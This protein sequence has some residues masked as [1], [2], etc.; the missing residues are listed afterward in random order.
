[1]RGVVNQ[2]LCWC[3][4][5]THAID[6]APGVVEVIR[7][8]LIVWLCMHE[9]RAAVSI[10]IDLTERACHLCRENARALDRRGVIEGVDRHQRLPPAIDGETRRDTVWIGDRCH[11]SVDAHGR[12]SRASR[13]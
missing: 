11:Q 1:M 12:C 10:R 3:A 5:T 7:G 6:H 13:G 9:K 2:T 8:R 4:A